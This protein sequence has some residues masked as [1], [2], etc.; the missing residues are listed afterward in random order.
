MKNQLETDLELIDSVRNGDTFAFTKIVGRY[1]SKVATT[2]FG[3]LG[4]TQ[5]AEDVG[6]EVFIRFFKSINQFRGESQLG[7][8]LT[9]I[10]INL[11][12]NELKRRKRSSFFSFEDWTETKIEE[13]VHSEHS[14]DLER[15]EI[16]R[17][18]IDQLPD[19]FKAVLV[20]RLMDGYSTE[21]TAKILEVPN[22]TV[23]SRL[24][25]AQQ[26]LKKILTPLE[27]DI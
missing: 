13:K 5:E 23:L 19:K 18:A 3:V 1:K 25:R 9:R 15:K 27:A 20:L 16:V 22:G 21:E 8:Y 6:Q 11:S 26:K 14:E 10:A 17:K 12:L 2:V 24:S 7:T 4:K